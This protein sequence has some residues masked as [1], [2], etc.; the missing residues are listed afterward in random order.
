MPFTRRSPVPALALRTR[1]PVNEH[2]T[3][4]LAR[5]DH[6]RQGDAFDRDG[7]MTKRNRTDLLNGELTHVAKA[8]VTLRLPR[9]LVEL[10]PAPTG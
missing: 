10:L 4:D 6:V 7:E 3:L 2:G 8:K 5:M 9:D 1:G